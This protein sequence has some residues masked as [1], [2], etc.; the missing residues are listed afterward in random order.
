[1]TQ[2]NTSSSIQIRSLF[3][4]MRAALATGFTLAALLTAPLCA[5]AQATDPV[6]DA[7]AQAGSPP[8]AATPA[9]TPDAAQ[10]APQKQDIT[11]SNPKPGK[12]RKQK[13]EKVVQ[14][15]DTK[16]E[17]KKVKKDN[18]LAGLDVKLPDKA[19]Y[20]KAEDAVKHGRYDVARLDLQTLLNTYPDSQYQ[21]RAKL[22]IADSWYKEGGTAALTQAEQEY[23]D[24][25]TFFPNAPEAA[26]AQMRVGD[27]YFRQMD[28]PDRDYTKTKHAEEEYRLM[29]QQFPDSP[30]IPQS[31]QRLREVQEIL[32]SRESEIA[33]F[34]ATHLNWPATIAR[35]QTV[36]DTYPLYSHMD[37][38]LV[39]LGDAY[40]AEARYV[41]SL[42]LPEA[43]KA[44]LERI[45]DDAAYAAFSK[46]ILEHS[47]APHVEDARDRI[48][49][50]NRPIPTP[51]PEQVAA[52]VALEN[53]RGQYTLSKRATVFFLHQADTVPAATI[54]APPLEDPPPTTAP[55][56]VRKAMADFSDSV[57]PATAPRTASTPI[58][59]DVPAT[60]TESGAPAST[61]SGAALSLEDV[62]AA[63]SVTSSGS[64]I[65]TS[66]PAASSTGSSAGNSMGIE[67]VQP[68]SGSGAPATP[69]T[70]TFP[71]TAAPE[72]AA[73]ATTP[74]PTGGIGPVGPPNAA[75]LAPIE[76]AAAAPD[77]INEA[78]PGSQSAQAAVA[79]GKKKPKPTFDK[80]DESS[81][82]HKK[83]KGL[84]KLNPF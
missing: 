23:H 18:V 22:A 27:I 32:A 62:P 81:S 43:G 29:A 8:A 78:T 74:A 56:I 1:M 47:A 26:E 57:N 40:A 25:I 73:P 4:H 39:G 54:G 68:S 19:L 50:M 7:A 38:V 51:T 31:N 14:S 42:R 21:M 75:P 83:K 2:S 34:Y 16:K 53:S 84:G 59:A 13:D 76:K 70:T 15:R 11:L 82:K 61:P 9:A 30:L 5:R 37:D 45:Y 33:G 66:V 65:V 24:F 10:T 52:S 69:P 77:A 36:V 72:N 41:R 28:K 80:S 64:P 49:G 67:I 6:P 79:A 17:V 12:Q 60:A 71:G 55:T 20:D 46:V 3:P 48:V 44:R 35:Y 63:G 58:S